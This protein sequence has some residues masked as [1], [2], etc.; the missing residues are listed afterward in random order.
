MDREG[1]KGPLFGSCAVTSPMTTLNNRPKVIGSLIGSP[2]SMLD[3]LTFLP[4]MMSFLGGTS[5]QAA[6]KR[7]I[8]LTTEQ[9]G[10]FY[11]FKS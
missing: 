11:P 4:G 6:L 10:A 3:E 8:L 5:C 2:L 7:D 9:V 1:Q